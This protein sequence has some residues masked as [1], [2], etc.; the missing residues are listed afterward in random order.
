MY[1]KEL[2]IYGFGKHEN[3]KIILHDGLSVIYGDNEAGKTTVQQFILQVFYGFPTKQEAQRN[4]EPRDTASYGGK[5]TI[6]HQ[7]YGECEIERV[8]GTKPSGDVVI[9]LP[10]K[11]RKDETFLP[12]LLYGYSRKSLEAIFA[13]SV[14]ELQGM[15][16]LSEEALSQ[17]LLASG[18][19]DIEKLT[20]M[21]QQVAR[22]AST[23]QLLDGHVQKISNLEKQIKEMKRN[24]ASY[25]SEAKTLREVER[26][27]ER[28]RT[29]K[30][31]LHQ[32]WQYYLTLQQQL[33]LLIERERIEATL[34][35]SQVLHFAR[36]E[37]KHF[38]FIKEEILTSETVIRNLRQ[39]RQQEEPALSFN[40]ERY[41]Q[42]NEMLT[43]ETRWYQTMEKIAR[44]QEEILI[45]ERD[46]AKQFRLLGVNQLE[47]QAVMLA[48]DVSIEKEEQ[49]QQVL[50]QLKEIDAQLSMQLHTLNDVH[51]ELEALEG[52]TDTEGIRMRRKE[53]REQRIRQMQFV[54]F[55]SAI[56]A[57][58]FLLMSWWWQNVY[59]FIAGIACVLVFLYI[60]QLR[61]RMS[62]EQF[63]EQQ[64]DSY[65]QRYIKIKEDIKVL[66]LQQ[67]EQEAVLQTYVQAFYTKPVTD[68]SLMKE[69]F[70][71]IRKLQEDAQTI[72]TKKELL[73]E[74]QQQQQ[75]LVAQVQQ[76]VEA[77]A[78]V[79]EAFP[80]VHKLR[81]QMQVA[82][83]AYS[84]ATKRIA[85]IDK[86]IERLVALIEARTQQQQHYFT[87]M[88]VADERE[89][90]EAYDEW[91][92]VQERKE[93]LTQLNEQIT[94]ATPTTLD[95]ET[96]ALQLETLNYEEQAT[97][98]SLQEKMQ[99][100]A[101]LTQLLLSKEDDESYGIIVQAYEQEKAAFHKA[102]A[103]WATKQ[104]VITAIE[105]TFSQL[106]ERKLPQVLAYA[107]EY[108]SVLT[109]RHYTKIFVNEDGYFEV[110]TVK[111]IRYRIIELSQATKQQAYTALRFAL[112]KTLEKSAPLPF[113]MDDPFVHFDR[114]RFMYMVQLIRTISK[115]RQIIYFT[116]QTPEIWLQ[117]EVQPL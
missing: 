21:A 84:R 100:Q 2:H 91:E 53:E 88:T 10:T 12:H 115:E 70:I 85:M 25:E 19:T 24:I 82:Y 63:V 5:I 86:E 105:Q 17:V 45:V 6:V 15:E 75:Q 103:Q 51:K 101:T 11:E 8:R 52:T 102:T 67:D 32:S 108:F 66:E 28:L 30:V 22:D 26:T 1:I 37:M 39:E 104:A 73:T 33:P 71:R 61:L 80:S 83:E 44:L 69:L 96:I 7:A 18:T 94:V 97:E 40:H 95:A 14:E 42:A 13:F 3:K 112:A 36:D 49:F 72:A 38:T 111:G 87:K 23:T 64:I 65:K 55:M 78:S 109:N 81:E 4:Y 43:H 59:T 98:K 41:A 68:R 60:V 90:Y 54:K 62:S 99:E 58:L 20:A 106:R 48:Q 46:N 47:E 116:C 35:T 76:I 93:R 74:A 57:V 77:D 107:S 50:R 56:A 79:A 27:I 31:K 29:E 92:Q 117:S 113:I 89:L 114:K 9:T 34:Q 16:R 110:E